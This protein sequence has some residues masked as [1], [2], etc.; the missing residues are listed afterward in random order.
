MAGATGPAADETVVT[1]APAA[2]P[3]R[4]GGRVLASSALPRGSAAG[5]ATRSVTGGT[6]VL[7]G[8]APA[9]AWVGGGETTG[10]PPAR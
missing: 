7:A 9:T 8:A 2:T 10:P 3:V 4:A 1:T 5:A 6:A